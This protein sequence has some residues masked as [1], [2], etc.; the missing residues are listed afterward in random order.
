[1]ETQTKILKL[2]EIYSILVRA[3]IDKM[4]LPPAGWCASNLDE[5]LWRATREYE[6][7]AFLR[8]TDALETSL[9]YLVDYAAR[10]PERV[11]LTESNRRVK[12]MCEELASEIDKI[13]R[14]PDE[15]ISEHGKLKAWLHAI[16]S[17]QTCLIYREETERFISEQKEAKRASR[18]APPQKNDSPPVSTS[19]KE[20]WQS[21]LA[22]NIWRKANNRLPDKSSEQPTLF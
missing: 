15:I 3:M 11:N 9:W 21:D 22:K 8:Q 18:V 20:K 17:V 10:M 14:S 4:P 2:D 16:L 12:Q 5:E 19:V 13:T 7:D 6:P 1:M